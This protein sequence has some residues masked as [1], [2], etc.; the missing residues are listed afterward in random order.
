MT[1]WLM[2]ICVD[3]DEHPQTAEIEAQGARHSVTSKGLTGP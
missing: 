2:D 1:H 3:K